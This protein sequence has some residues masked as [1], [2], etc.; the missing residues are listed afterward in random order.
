MSKAPIIIVGAIIALL[1]L[2]FYSFGY[3]I[4]SGESE[5]EEAAMRC[6][7]SAGVVRLEKL[8][9]DCEAIAGGRPLIAK[10][11]DDGE[12]IFSWTDENGGP[13]EFRDFRP[14]KA[15]VAADSVTLVTY[16]CFD[17][18]VEIE[19]SGLHSASPLI[20]LRYG[21]YQNVKKKVL[22]KKEPI[23]IITAQRASR[24]AD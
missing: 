4:F 24:V 15:Y 6:A 18:A 7:E 20:T 5:K 8:F 12:Y 10:S 19:V 14:L 21:D 1:V 13:E 11:N 9:S 3:R 17:E 23:K 22:W 16:R 2:A